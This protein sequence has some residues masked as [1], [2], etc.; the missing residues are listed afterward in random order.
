MPD[1]T[2]Q[3]NVTFTEEGDRTRA[4]AVLTLASRRFHGF[5]R[6]KRAPADE[7]ELYA[8]SAP[9]LL[10]R[11]HRVPDE[12]SSLM[13]IGHNPALEQL[14]LELARPS[15]ERRRLETKHPTAT[16]ALLESRGTSW[17]DLDRNHATLAVCVRPP[18][19]AE[20][21]RVNSEAVYA[22]RS[23]QIVDGLGASPSA[24]VPAR[25]RPYLPGGRDGP[26]D[27]RVR[28]RR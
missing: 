18:R 1:Q 24:T 5:G 4:D 6:A 7:P 11:V 23:A 2:W 10:E 14:A 19:R 9:T 3:L 21:R 15:I 12:I 16:L 25:A 13:R 20:L 17:R 28:R 27:A 22:D 8:A 26:D